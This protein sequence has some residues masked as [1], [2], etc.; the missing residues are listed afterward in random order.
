[1][2][3]V[4]DIRYPCFCFLQNNSL[5]TPPS[6]QTSNHRYFLYN[7]CFCF[8]QNNSLPPPYSLRHARLLITDIFYT[9]PV[10]ASFKITPYLLHTPSVLPD[11]SSPIFFIQ[12]LFLLSLSSF[13]VFCL[14]TDLSLKVT[15]TFLWSSHFPVCPV[16]ILHFSNKMCNKNLV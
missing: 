14:K 7:P 12:C 10:F 8:L 13:C 1:M 11:F 16:N 15:D 4:I 5:P 6:C 9:M 3:S 2:W